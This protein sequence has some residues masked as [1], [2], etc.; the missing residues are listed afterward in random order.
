MEDSQ[1]KAMSLLIKAFNCMFYFMLIF[2]VV[3]LE[4]LY[5]EIESYTNVIN[6]IKIKQMFRP[7]IRIDSSLNLTSVLS[8]G[9]CSNFYDLV[10]DGNKIFI[11]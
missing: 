9:I 8:D 7:D 1:H 11:L 2:N 6:K 10:L 3:H 4:S 5:C